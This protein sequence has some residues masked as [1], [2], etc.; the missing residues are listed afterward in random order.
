MGK[1]GTR[2][3]SEAIAQRTGRRRSTYTNKELQKDMEKFLETGEHPEMG[4]EADDYRQVGSLPEVD[5]R[6]PC[7]FLDVG[8][9]GEKIGRLV[10]ELFVDIV[11]VSVGHF[12]NICGEGVQGSLKGSRCHKLQPHFAAYFRKTRENW[13]VG[14]ET[15][16]QHVD[17]GCI[18]I[19]VTNDEMV[20][21]LGVARALDNTH[22]VIGRVVL[23]HE[24]LST[25]NDV[26]TNQ[27]DVPVQPIAILDCGPTNMSGTHDSFAASTPGSS[28]RQPQSAEE[29]IQQLREDTSQARDELREAL[30]VGLSASRKRQAESEAAGR[31]RPSV[32]QRAMLDSVFPGLSDTS[33]SGTSDGDDQ[34]EG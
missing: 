5:P 24:V 20:L 28:S 2:F 13:P 23:G 33:S 1:G 6:R 29:A 21:S 4:R 17:S 11:A 10:I 27:N 31:G 16:L 15:K 19:A 32:R 3:V 7:V 30:E 34:G 26:P 12:Q 8:R 25:L 9:A 18:S 22:Q 14:R